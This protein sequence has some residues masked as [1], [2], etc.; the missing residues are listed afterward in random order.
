[1]QTE[2]YRVGILLSQTLKVVLAY[3]DCLVPWRVKLMV[4]VVEVVV[5]KATNVTQLPTISYGV[6]VRAQGKVKRI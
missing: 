2:Q 6:L 4:E 5:D 3:E 1:M